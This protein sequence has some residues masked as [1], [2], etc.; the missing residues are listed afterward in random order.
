MKQTAFLTFSLLIL[1]SFPGVHGQAMTEAERLAAQE[2]R[3]TEIRNQQGGDHIGD[4][5]MIK[6][7]KAYADISPSKVNKI[8]KEEKEEKLRIEKLIAPNPEDLQKY[9]SLIKTSRGGLFRLFPNSDCGG[10]YVVNI[11]QKCANYVSEHSTY[12]FRQ[13][14]YE[15]ESSYAYID[16][17][18]KDNDL[19]SR[20]F[21]SQGIFT[22]L[23]D[24]PIEDVSL[25]SSGVDFLVNF[26][27]QNEPQGA[28]NQYQQI[29][30]GIKE[31]GYFYSNVVKAE[32]NTTYGLRIIAYHFIVP[33]LYVPYI[34]DNRFFT[35]N[36]DNRRD[37]TIAFRII[38]K[39]DD[40][41]IT[42]VWKE[43]K[44]QLSP[45]LNYQKN[46]KLEDFKPKN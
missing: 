35:I 34:G 7:N 6:R 40:G 12:S 43:L 20:G 10:K 19:V 36:H 28:R 8:S 38:R 31:N 32:L 37:L 46:E 30:Q 17:Q 16:I 9:D 24:V 27:P 18:F 11:S 25:T 29:T 39:E 41:N 3:A 5:G 23:G 2:R 26:K 22:S 15:P 42:I 44:N 21:L 1:F 14:A 13:K 45:K 33:S 4:N